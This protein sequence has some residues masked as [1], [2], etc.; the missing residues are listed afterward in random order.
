MRKTYLGRVE[1]GAVGAANPAGL[2]KNGSDICKVDCELCPTVETVRKSISEMRWTFLYPFFYSF[3]TYK[4]R[5]MA[6]KNLIQSNANFYQTNILNQLLS[7]HLYLGN[8]KKINLIFTADEFQHLTGLGQYL[9]ETVR[10]VKK[11]SNVFRD[12][13][14]GN[15]DINTF[16]ETICDKHFV[17]EKMENF[18]DLTASLD[19]DFDIYSY[20]KNKSFPNEEAKYVTISK[21]KNLNG[22]DT[23][24]LLFIDTKKYG[25]YF[26]R[27]FVANPDKEKVKNMV[28]LLKPVKILCKEKNQKGMTP[29]VLQLGK[30]GFKKE[31]FIEKL[32][33]QEQ[34]EQE[35]INKEIQNKQKVKE[36]I[37][38][39]M[40]QA[41]RQALAEKKNQLDTLK[42]EISKHHIIRNNYTDMGLEIHVDKNIVIAFDDTNI[43]E[44]QKAIKELTT[45]LDKDK[46]QTIQKIQPTIDKD[47]IEIDLP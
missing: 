35:K 29:M 41:Q 33:P 32:T 25:E 6:M 17:K 38:Q 3:F 15:Y 27:S 14:R 39:Q 43:T 21:F 1:I 40:Q 19:I 46:T 5:R 30:A 36:M 4:N 45:I 42:L 26:I 23:T 2:I 24:I 13:K 22:K 47:E 7:Y 8:G 20:H 16:D 10:D 18:Q 28:A 44:I 11:S 12:A 9:K 34:K 37:K 31:D